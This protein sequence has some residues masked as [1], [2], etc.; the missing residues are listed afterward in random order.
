MRTMA[1]KPL[2]PD[3]ERGRLQVPEVSA[4][5]WPFTVPIFSL[6]HLQSGYTVDDCLRDERAEFA[7]AL[8]KRSQLTWQQIIQVG[9]HQLG[10]ETIARNAI[11]VGL[12][13]I[14]TPDVTILAFRYNYPKP[15]IGFRTENIFHVVW[16]DPHLS[17][18][19]TTE[20]V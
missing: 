5:D 8:W 6:Q 10:S 14:I 13:R 19:T 3:R 15:M 2:E 7:S 18:R 20:M 1:K 12:P 17:G 9:R 16:I 4:K 11:R